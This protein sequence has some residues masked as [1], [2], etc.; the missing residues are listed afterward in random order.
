LFKDA[1]IEIKNFYT[2]NKHE[3]LF[4]V[5]KRIIPFESAYIFFINPEN[6]RLEYSCNSKLLQKE[7]RIET[8]L[9]QELFNGVL[10]ERFTEWINVLRINNFLAAPL[11]IKNSVFGV[12][13]IEGGSFSENDKI[14]F[15]TCASIIANITKD[16]EINK[17]LSMQT[18]ALQEVILET[19]NENK[20]IKKSEEVKTNFLSHVSHE[21]R[22]PLTSIIGYADMLMKEFAGDLN[23]K[24]KEF[25]NDIQVSGIHLLG[26]IN[27]ILDL[28]KLETGAMKLHLSEFDILQC[29]NEAC[30][31]IK[32]LAQK[33][34]IE[35]WS[36]VP[37][38]EINADYQ[39]IQQIL[40][41]LLS[42]A[43][44][45]TPEHGHIEIKATVN[46]ENL[47]IS[48][49]DNGIGIAPEN[50]IRI[51]E[52]YEQIECSNKDAS[53]GLGLAITTELIKLH[54][55]RIELIS[56]LGKGAEFRVV[57]CLTF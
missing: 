32:P 48:V 2:I 56:E 13:L 4:D 50:Q 29:V 19:N 27:E 44:K 26:M 12:L 15:Q 41:N 39:K 3:E 7:F 37:S 1:I 46:G 40:Y 22:T 53:T 52:K 34:N 30:N 49:K 16:K 35:V 45:F 9:G 6:I 31:V 11:K 25:V 42:N 57:L 55:G 24:Q 8:N 14:V 17:I 36:D 18:K 38:I 23:G 54:G 10:S 21:I 33:K 28:A 5:L 20:K 43:V 47:M 51:F